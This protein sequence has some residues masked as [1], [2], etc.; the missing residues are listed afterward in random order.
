MREVVDDP[1]PLHLQFLQHAIYLCYN[2]AMMMRICIWSHF[3][4]SIAI[5]LWKQE[6]YTHP[7]IVINFMG[8][9]MHFAPYL[10]LLARNEPTPWH[11]VRTQCN[12]IVC[13]TLLLLLKDTVHLSPKNR[14][15]SSSLIQW[16]FMAMK[17]HAANE[18]L[19]ISDQLCVLCYYSNGMTISV[20][21]SEISNRLKISSRGYPT[22]T[23]SD[24]LS[25]TW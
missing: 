9:Y 10:Q 11:T 21:I 23:I 25:A 7:W 3:D 22:N 2:C 15:S 8:P 18:C 6:V 16:C 20:P 14:I 1:P 13:P 5:R 12:P 19:P 24:T 4:W 17:L